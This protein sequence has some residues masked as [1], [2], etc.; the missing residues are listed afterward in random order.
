MKRLAAVLA[1]LAVTATT[2]P[3]PTQPAR[4]RRLTIG[5]SI[6]NRRILAVER[7]D[8]DNHRKVLVVGCIHGNECAGRAIVRRLREMPA[9]DDLDLWLIPDLNPDGSAAGT[10]QN[11]RGV[12]LNRNFSYRWE[13]IGEPWDTYH[14]GPRPFSEPEARTAR[15]FVRRHR[16]DI[17]IYYHQHMSLVVKAGR[18]SHRHVQRRY[19]RLV[20]L[21]L[22]DLPFI[23]GTA[24]SWQNHHYPGHLAFVVELPAGALGE[25]S[26]RHHARAVLEIGRNW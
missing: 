4:A 13:P 10:R 2:S 7:G 23:P 12:D 22:R 5:R 6:E 19:A 9:P 1:L 14:S 26:A 20:G 24:V 18:R 11:G 21:P 8:F 15:D 17:T 16:P 3:L 25:R